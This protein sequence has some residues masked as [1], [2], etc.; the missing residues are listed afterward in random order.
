[1]LLGGLAVS[2]VLSALLP[3]PVAEAGA[4]PY[5]AQM[6]AVGATLVAQ[7]VSSLATVTVCAPVLLLHAAALWWRPSLA[8]ATLVVGLVGGVATLAVAIVLGG[9][10]YDSRTP[11]LLARLT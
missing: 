3:Y 4:N 11:Q 7:L 2:A 10:V 5:A 8:A 6:G 9:R 1:V